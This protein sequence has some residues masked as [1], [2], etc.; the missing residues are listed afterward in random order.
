MA[1]D[2]NL[3]PVNPTGN[4][5]IK[6]NIFFGNNLTP[7]GTFSNIPQTIT[8]PLATQEQQAKITLTLAQIQEELRRNA[9]EQQG[10]T[11]DLAWLDT[12]KLQDYMERVRD[13]GNITA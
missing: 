6:G 4:D 5:A 7:G 8:S 2:N 13:K 1:E 10:T 9:Q 12:G 3:I 11:E